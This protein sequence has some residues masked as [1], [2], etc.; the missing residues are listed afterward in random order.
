MPC[1]GSSTKDEIELEIDSLQHMLR[2]C[3][4]VNDRTRKR[5]RECTQIAIWQ[6][7]LF[8]EERRHWYDA[9]RQFRCC[10]LVAGSTKPQYRQQIHA[11][12][13]VA[14]RCVHGELHYLVKWAEE[15]FADSWQRAVDLPCAP[16]IEKFEAQHREQ[17][18]VPD[19]SEATPEL[20]ENKLAKLVMLRRSLGCASEL[21]DLVRTRE[22]MKMRVSKTDVEL[23]DAYVQQAQEHAESAGASKKQTDKSSSRLDAV[24]Q[25]APELPPDHDELPGKMDPKADSMHTDHE[26]WILLK[27]M[28]ELQQSTFDVW[29]QQASHEM[30]MDHMFFDTD[31]ES[32]DTVT[33][34]GETTDDEEKS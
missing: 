30:P 21:C 20:D 2:S 3:A 4:G 6:Q 8:A 5:L 16:L 34:M 32:G 15:G 33:E 14:K 12:E 10:K 25:N 1:P 29:Q 18:Q 28:I 26:Y 11:R 22:K 24:D 19:N 17:P 31:S 23:F 27:Q 13:I 7:Q 9:D